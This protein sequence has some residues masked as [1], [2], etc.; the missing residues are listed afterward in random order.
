MCYTP[1]T[2]VPLGKI[3][4]LVKSESTK[5][6]TALDKVQASVSKNTMKTVITEI[7]K[8]TFNEHVDSFTEVISANSE[9]TRREI[10]ETIQNNNRT[11]MSEVVRTSKMQMDD[12]AVAREARKCSLIIRDVTESDSHS[13][14]ERIHQDREFAGMLFDIH[15]N[16]IVKVVRAGPPITDAANDRRVTR[17]MIVTVESPE[18]AAQLHNHGR[19]WRARDTYGNIYWVNPDLIKADREAAYH[20]R[21]AARGR[22]RGQHAGADRSPPHNSPGRPGNIRGRANRNERHS[23]SPTVHAA[24]NHITERR[25]STSTVSSQD[26]TS[27]RQSRQSQR[28]GSHESQGS[29]ADVQ[30]GL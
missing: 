22:R 29:N 18:L 7:M 24:R 9:N 17:P 20:A 11:V 30:R 27:S 4:A 21:M 26:S 13:Q 1:P 14:N 5:L 2:T 19:G 15:Q 12:D 16:R 23:V 25:L 10:A 8:D 28:S 3:E 6:S